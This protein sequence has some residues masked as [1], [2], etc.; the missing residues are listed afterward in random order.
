MRIRNIKNATE[1][2]NDSQ[3]VIKN[4]FDY[5]GKWQQVFGNNNP[6][7]LEIGMGK[8]NFIM[9]MAKNNKDINF[10]GL[11]KY[12]AIVAKACNKLVDENIPNLRIINIDALNLKDIFDKEIDTIYLNFSDP[13][14]KKRTIKRRL[15]SEI[16]LNIYTEIFK[17]TN[18]IKMK[19]DNVN[20]FEYSI[21]SL[22]NFGYK[23]DDISL[24]LW[25]TDKVYSET[26]YENKFRTKGVKINYLYAT[27]EFK[28]ND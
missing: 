27:K 8:G 14:P 22:T 24:D 21:V 4:P 2:I 17:G 5:K 12:S 6:I 16:F 15:T 28:N 19:T 1:L 18:I 20:L 9:D 3:Y 25:N 23:I 13:W 11:E 26:E 7:H 10:I